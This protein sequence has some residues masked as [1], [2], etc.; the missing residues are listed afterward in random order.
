VSATGPSYVHLFL[1]PVYQHTFLETFFL[2]FFLHKNKS[3]NLVHF[4]T[5]DDG[6]IFPKYLYQ[7]NILQGI[8][9]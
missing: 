8:I 1:P 6:F 4:Y 7:N 5:E 2:A 9:M 3:S